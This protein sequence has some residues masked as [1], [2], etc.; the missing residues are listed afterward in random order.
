[1]TT[2]PKDGMSRINQLLPFL[3]IAKSTVWQWVKIGKFPQPIKLSGNVTVWR[4]SDIHDWL[5][6]QGT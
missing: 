2:L 1:M 5:E 4:N 6:Q 3:P